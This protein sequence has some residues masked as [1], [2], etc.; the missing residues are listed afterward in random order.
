MAPSQIP[1]YR[2]G[3]GSL[4]RRS[5]G[6]CGGF[7]QEAVKTRQFLAVGITI[8]VDVTIAV[9]GL[10]I[11]VAVGITVLIGHLA[12]GVTVAIVFLAIVAIFGLHESVRVFSDFLAE[13]LDGPATDKFW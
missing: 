6:F 3:E 13:P 2:S 9:V 7:V 11:G 10:A 1:G 8:A 5:G 4:R 12:V